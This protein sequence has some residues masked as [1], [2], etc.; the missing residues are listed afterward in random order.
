MEGAGDFHDQ[1]ANTPAPEAD[2]LFDHATALDTTVDVFD[3]NAPAG[4]GLIGCFLLLAQLTAPRLL[5]R[6]DDFYSIEGEGQKAEILKQLTALRQL[7]VGKVGDALV[8]D[9]TF[10]GTA[11]EEDAE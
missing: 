9:P 6:L 8:V 10:K 5:E 1:I 11:Q 7:V 2:A 4:Q 3:T